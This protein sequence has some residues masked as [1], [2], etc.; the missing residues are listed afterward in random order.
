[1]PGA[2]VHH[3][4]VE[5]FDDDAGFGTVRGEDASKLFFH[6][7]AITD[8]SRSIEVGTPVS[9]LVVPGHGGRWEASAV[10]RRP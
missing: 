1:M 6:C 3:G 4:S 10:T 8:G 7:T 2:S 5:A 9:Y